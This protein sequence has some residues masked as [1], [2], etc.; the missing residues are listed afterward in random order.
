MRRRSLHPRKAREAKRAKVRRRRVRLHRRRRNQKENPRAAKTPARTP[1]RA[2]RIR[3]KAKAKTKA[4][5]KVR[6]RGS[7][8]RRMCEELVSLQMNLPFFLAASTAD[9]S[10][11]VTK[12]EHTDVDTLLANVF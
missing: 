6:A 9:S 8:K 5:A 4:K 3:E 7:G 10:P 12:A 2:P 11:D 1:A